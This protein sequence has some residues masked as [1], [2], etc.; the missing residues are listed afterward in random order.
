LRRFI[1]LS[2][3]RGGDG[4]PDRG[5]E[6]VEEVERGKG[7]EEVEEVEEVRMQGRVRLAP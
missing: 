6:E 5:V 2:I 1:G 7:V 3:A 4:L